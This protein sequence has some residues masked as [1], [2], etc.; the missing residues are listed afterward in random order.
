M[1]AGLLLQNSGIV[2]QVVSREV[3]ASVDHEIIILDDLS[4]VFG[5]EALLVGYDIHIAV[6]ASNEALSR[7]CFG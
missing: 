6:E 4:C 3:I 2:D 7:F 5:R 1:R